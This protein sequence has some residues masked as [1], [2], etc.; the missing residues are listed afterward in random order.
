MYTSLVSDQLIYIFE[1]RNYCN[2]GTCST[3][4][5]MANQLYSLRRDFPNQTTHFSAVPLI[6]PLTL[7]FICLCPSNWHAGAK[8][9]S[10]PECQTSLGTRPSHQYWNQAITLVSCL[11]AMA[12]VDAAFTILLVLLINPQILWSYSSC[13][14]LCTLDSRPLFSSCFNL[15]VKITFFILKGI[16]HTYKVFGYQ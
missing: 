11:A 15:A 13:P 4:H 9:V 16:R 6:S 12:Y 5:S 14:F 3:L 1:E 8:L 7:P 10:E 2:R